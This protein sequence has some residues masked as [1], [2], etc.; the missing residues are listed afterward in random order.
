M[1]EPIILLSE[2]L[3]LITNSRTFFYISDTSRLTKGA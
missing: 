2:S 3:S 1:H